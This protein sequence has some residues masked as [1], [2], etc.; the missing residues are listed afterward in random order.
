[1]HKKFQFM[2]FFA[3]KCKPLLMCRNIANS[4]YYFHT[5]GFVKLDDLLKAGLMRHHCKE[6]IFSE[7][8]KVN[9]AGKSRFEIVSKNDVEV[10]RAAY[11][12]KFAP[13]SFFE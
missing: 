13:V 12:R 11:G 6:E 9:V 3:W 5:I 2:L 1:M 10:I 4:P 7:V 8:K